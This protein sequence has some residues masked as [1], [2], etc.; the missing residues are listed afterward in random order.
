MDLEIPD[1][2]KELRNLA[3]KETKGNREI[4]NTIPSQTNS[5]YNHPLKLCK[6]NIGTIEKP[7][8]VMVGDYWNE[9]TSQEI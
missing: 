9:E 5:S 1:D 7:R 2:L 8:I 6:G 4:Q 3:I